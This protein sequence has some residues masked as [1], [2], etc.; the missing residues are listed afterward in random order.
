L[1]KNF[2]IFELNITA[3]ICRHSVKKSD[4]SL[5]LVLIKFKLSKSM[6]QCMYIC[7]KCNVQQNTFTRQRCNFTAYTCSCTPVEN[8]MHN[9]E[10]ISTN[11]VEMVASIPANF[12]LP[13][14]IG[15]GDG[16]NL[17]QTN[18]FKSNSFCLRQTKRTVWWR[19]L[20]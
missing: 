8:A 15:Q 5:T 17:I 6:L 1:Y 13:R 18:N 10:L 9:C 19:N 11:S 12:N 3:W 7:I 20:L 14:T 16:V 2:V 4:E